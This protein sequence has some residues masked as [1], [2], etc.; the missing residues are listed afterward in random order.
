MGVFITKYILTPSPPAKK[1][2]NLLLFVFFSDTGK[3][4]NL[5]DGF[6]GFHGF[7]RTVGNRDVFK[8]YVEN[9]QTLKAYFGN[10]Q[11]FKVYVGNRQTFKVYVGNRQTFKVYV[12]NNFQGV[13]TPSRLINLSTTSL[14]LPST[15]SPWLLHCSVERTSEA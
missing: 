10:R 14:R 8:V 1:T 5:F 4:K 13:S 11:A 2:T 15:L 3:P 9:R 12:G 6:H 7:E